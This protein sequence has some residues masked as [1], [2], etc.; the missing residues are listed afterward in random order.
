[1]IVIAGGIGSGKSVVARILRL[2]GYGV[3]DCDFEAKRLME[4]D[5]VIISM[6]KSEFGEAIYR[7]GRLDR[8]KL[9]EAIFSNPEARKKVNSAVHTAVKVKISNWREESELN[10][11]VE[12]AIAAESG[13][14]AE[15]SGIWLVEA[16]KT[17]RIERVIKRDNRTEE[18]IRAIVSIQE[19]E[20]ERLAKGGVRIFRISNNPKDDVLLRIDRLLESAI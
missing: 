18:Q 2:K 16:D 20:E 15:A 1:M 13:I 12:T 19:K 7:C 8:K 11:F 14:A 10:I 17:T 9:A 3:F 6:L 4:E 5:E